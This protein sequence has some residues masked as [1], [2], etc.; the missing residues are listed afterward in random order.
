M[1]AAENRALSPPALSLPPRGARAH[2]LAAAGGE[3]ADAK[4]L[5]GNNGVDTHTV[6]LPL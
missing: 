1:R 4:S 5:L 2:A 3:L 6:E